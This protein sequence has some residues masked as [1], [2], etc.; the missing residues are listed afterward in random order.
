MCTDDHDYCEDNQSDNSCCCGYITRR[1]RSEG[2]TMIAIG[3][4]EDPK[5][6]DESSNYDLVHE[7]FICDGPSR[8]SA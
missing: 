1:D 8:K 3:R 6:I 5:K 4:V 2:F 7:M